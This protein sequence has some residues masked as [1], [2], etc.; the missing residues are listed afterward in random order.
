MA[1]H[2]ARMTP[3][4]PGVRMLTMGICEGEV[5]WYPENTC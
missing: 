2:M 5:G 3:E 4:M 1:D